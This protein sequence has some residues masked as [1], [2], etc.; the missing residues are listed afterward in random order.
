M[1]NYQ[2]VMNP[3]D[4]EYST[5][6][7]NSLR[8][9]N[10]NTSGRYE[11]SAPRTG[12]YALPAANADK[13]MEELKKC[14]FFRTRATSIP[15]CQKDQPIA[16][17]NTNELAQW[18]PENEPIPEEESVLKVL[19][20][21]SCKLAS[22]TKL[23]ESM[24]E[25]SGFDF[26]DWVIRNFAKRFGKAE[27]AA[28]LNGT[29]ENEPTGILAESGGA[30][31]GVTTSGDAPTFDEVMNLFYSLAPEHRENAIWV[32]NDT[33]ALHLR[34]LN[35]SAGNYLWAPSSEKLLG[36]EVII[37]NAMPDIG[38]GSKPIAFGDFSYYWILDRF[39]F[40]VAVLKEKY[41]L[42]NQ[43]GYIGYEF[44]DA[45]LIRPEAIKV[46]QVKA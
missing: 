8:R 40:S 21:E 44:L 38:S 12:A 2:T 9:H 34:K 20:F 16:V 10:I 35:D 39:P 31:V 26:E 36:K 42:S 4:K 11:A 37:S 15:M 28:F 45:K 33:T 41:V 25:D 1:K 6:F 3:T 43:R 19:T 24:L 46:L 29:G 32:M 27:E 17:M 22:I 23:F 5:E 30:E 13:Y 14:N 18:I 7:W